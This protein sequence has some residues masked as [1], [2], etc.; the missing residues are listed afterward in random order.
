MLVLFYS[1][2]TIPARTMVPVSTG[3]YEADLLADSHRFT[4][5]AARFCQALPVNQSPEQKH[6]E[7]VF[8]Y[9]L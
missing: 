7:Q 5:Y 8:H 6:V 4:V 3:Y 1:K 9:T 2:S